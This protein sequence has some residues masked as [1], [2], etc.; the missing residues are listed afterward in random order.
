MFETK[1]KSVIV[2]AN[3]F[4][5]SILSL[6]AVTRIAKEEQYE[7]RLSNYVGREA[8]EAELYAAALSN[9]ITIG[10]D[11]NIV[12]TTPAADK[13]FGYN[14]DELKGRPGT[15]LIPER[16]KK[17][18]AVAVDRGF[19]EFNGSSKVA[20]IPRC[21]GLRKDGTEISLE[22][23]TRIITT[24]S[25]KVALAR[26]TRTKDIRIVPAGNFTNYSI[27]TPE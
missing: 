18:H 10:E 25:G 12:S 17:A 4:G 21:E 20:I 19:Q 22:V 24:D 16:Y 15:V 13:L 9:T 7:T 23:R 1:Y 2:M 11:G 26:F 14:R 6:I 8:L 27:D 5:W 3:I